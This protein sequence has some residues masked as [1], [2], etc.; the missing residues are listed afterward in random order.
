MQSYHLQRIS[1]PA[2]IYILQLKTVDGMA[3][4]RV[5]LMP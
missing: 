4:K 5:L 1:L 2:G 3:N